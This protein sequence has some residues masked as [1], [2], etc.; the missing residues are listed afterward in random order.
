MPERDIAEK[1]MR[2]LMARPSRPCMAPWVG[3]VHE[4]AEGFTKLRA[5]L[6][7]RGAQA[8]DYPFRGTPNL[9][10][11][12]DHLRRGNE[13][14]DSIVIVGGGLAAAR[15]AQAFRKAGGEGAVTILSADSDPPYNRPPLSKGF[16]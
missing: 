1:L 15:V 2:G 13:M 9:Q 3:L 16:L 11:E 4:T 7:T 5:G 8:Y 12:R 14:T 6:R 10:P